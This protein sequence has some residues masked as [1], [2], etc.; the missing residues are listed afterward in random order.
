MFQLLQ[1]NTAGSSAYARRR[2][3]SLHCS[4]C[5]CEVLKCTR[6]LGF[7][8]CCAPR[9]RTML[10]LL[11]RSCA[12]QRTWERRCLIPKNGYDARGAARKRVGETGFDQI[13][14]GGRWRWV[15]EVGGG[16]GDGGGGGGGGVDNC[17][18]QQCMAACS[19]G[20]CSGIATWIAKPNFAS[21]SHFSTPAALALPARECQC[22]EGRGAGRATTARG[23]GKS[24]RR[25]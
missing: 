7:T 3:H 6:G 24:H 13:L 17:G 5:N 15:M 16:G 11:L 22:S 8:C 21:W 14:D 20:A 18:H 4:C 23:A 9:R 2:L 1:K 10:L 12:V 25:R 19:G